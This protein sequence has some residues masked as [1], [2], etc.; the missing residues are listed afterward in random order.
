MP[1]PTAADEPL[2]EPPGV[3]LGSCGFWVLCHG[4]VAANSV[5]VVLPTMT[6]PAS[7]SACTLA[8]S[9]CQSVPSHIGE[10]WPVGMSAVSMMSLMA[11]GMP[12]IGD[13]GLPSR[14]RAVE[15]SAAAI[16]PSW[17]KRDEGADGRIELDDALEAFVEVGARRGL[18]RAQIGRQRHIAAE[19]CCRSWP[20]RRRFHLHP[21]RAPHQVKLHVHILRRAI[22]VGLRAHPDHAVAQP[23]LQ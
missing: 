18:A 12:S 2:D 22:G 1:A 14:Q 17:F 23:P 7:R 11:I 3:R 20:H 9:R 15:A 13:S 10:P 21:A 4:W 19:S 5:V 16:A 6:A 8:E